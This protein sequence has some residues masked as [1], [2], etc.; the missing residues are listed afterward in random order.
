MAFVKG[1]VNLDNLLKRKDYFL[2]YLPRSIYFMIKIGLIL[3]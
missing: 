2:V 3:A 1:Y